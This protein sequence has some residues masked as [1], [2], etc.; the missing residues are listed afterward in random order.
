MIT[1]EW[2][3]RAFSTGAIVSR[4]R[5]LVGALRA[6]RRE[7]V[8][9]KRGGGRYAYSGDE[10]WHH[11]SRALDGHGYAVRSYV[12]WGATVSPEYHPAGSYPCC[13]GASVECFVRWEGQK[14][15]SRR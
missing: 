13:Q 15:G 12:R 11:P 14:A 5:T 7:D 10:I 6:L 3:L 1:R 8:A 2:V 4:H 9:A